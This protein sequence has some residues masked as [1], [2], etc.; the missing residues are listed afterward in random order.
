M[1]KLAITALAASAALSG[2]ADQLDV[3]NPND[4]DVARAYASPALVEGVI[5]GLAVSIFNAERASESIN[6]QAKILSGENFSP[7][8]NF[9]MATRAAVPR[10]LISNE[11]G[12]EMQTG[13]LA[14]WTSFSIA[15]RTGANALK[16]L[17]ILLA[18]GQSLGSPAQ[19][20]RARAFAWFMIGHAQGNLAL[21]YDS[22]AIVG[23]NLASSDIPP[24]SSAADAMRVSIAYMDSAIAVAQSP[25]ATTGTNG[26]PLPTTWINGQTLSRDDFIRLIRSW[27]ARFRAGVARTPAERAAVDWPAVI[28]DATNGITADLNIG[29]GNSSGWSGN[30]DTGQ[31]YVQSYGMS[32]Y[33]YWG[34]ADVSG[35][36]DAWLATPRDER[37]AFLVV[38]PDKRW[39]AGTTRLAQQ[40][41]AVTVGNMQPG[42]YIRNRQVGQDIVLTGPGDTWYEHRRYGVTNAAG[43]NGTYTDMSQTEM[44]MLAAEGYMRANNVAA[45]IPLINK[46]RV[47]NNLTAIPTT[48]T[49]RDAPISTDLATCVPR[50]PVGPNFTSTACGSVWEAMKY[51][52]RLE[53]AFTGYLVWYA[54]SRGW[55]DLIQGT[56]IEWP[57][58]YQEMQARQTKY[59][60]GTRAA[61]PST[62]GFK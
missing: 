53:T 47:R 3:K 32:S 25:A 19:N 39:P 28:A 7:L 57:V 56:I 52:K 13:N 43:G 24:L 9:G 55:G 18:S 27:K 29:I 61:G 23:P 62:Y 33:W 8:A 50:V 41:Q 45:A 1:R 21:G 20:A 4:P 42:V 10:V 31:S 17:D 37:K 6:T 14:N 35:G 38:T 40:N 46:S 60:N 12:N 34:M 11:L 15:A 36:Y 26:F 59:Y 22:V 54:D 49:N 44:D 48:I 51:E 2:C 30:F 58:P 16:A 5:S